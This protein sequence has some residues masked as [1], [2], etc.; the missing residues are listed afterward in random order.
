MIERGGGTMRKSSSGLT[1]GETLI[2]IVVVLFVMIYVGAALLRRG[3]FAPHPP[4]P[5]SHCRSNLEQIGRAIGAYYNVYRDYF[6]FFE[7]RR[8]S[9]NPFVRGMDDY[10]TDTENQFS[11][12]FTP[13]PEQRPMADGDW[14]PGK[15]SWWATD[16]LTLLYPDYLTNVKIFACPSTDDRPRMFVLFHDVPREAGSREIVSRKRILSH[17][18]TEHERAMSG[19]HWSSYGYNNRI[20]HARAGATHVVAGDMDH[21]AMDALAPSTANHQGGGN[22]LYFDGSVRW[23]NSYF[24]SNHSE[25][26]I[27]QR[28]NAIGWGDDEWAPETDV[29]LRRP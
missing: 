12:H 17:F 20:H 6:P 23:D 3:P 25:D 18:G 5:R 4:G 24:A 9:Q 1:L 22:F 15:R 26:H 19:P 10:P 7:S 16:S 11:P 27:F 8:P 28:Q 13:F 29:W 14:T 2:V 21:T